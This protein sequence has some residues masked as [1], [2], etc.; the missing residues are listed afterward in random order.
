MINITKVNLINLWNRLKLDNKKVSLVI[1]V[2]LA[3]IY[4]DYGF[5]M[6]L[7]LQGIRAIT[8]KVI[9]LKGDIADLAKDLPKMQDLKKNMETKS[10]TGIPELKK[11]ISEGEIPLLLQAI[12]DMANQ[13]KVRVMQINT[14]KDEKNKEEVIAGQKLMPITIRLDLSCAYHSLG[15]FINLLEN[16]KQFIEVQDMKITRDSRDY[17]LENAS[18]ALKVYVKK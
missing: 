5:L 18:L 12:S 17:F 16:A 4:A 7:Q 14:P 15:S 2:S 9:K 8:P 3:I 13:S 10:Q 6:K 1:A 11:I